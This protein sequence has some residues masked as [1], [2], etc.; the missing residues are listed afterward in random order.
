[1]VS[2]PLFQSRTGYIISSIQFLCLMT[3]GFFFAQNRLALAII[4]LIVAIVCFFLV[5]RIQQSLNQYI[6][7]FFEALKN[8][9]TSFQYPSVIKNKSIRALLE[10]FNILKDRFQHIKVDAEINERYYRAIIRHSA[11]GLLV[12]HND[13]IELINNL[14]CMYA[15]ISSESKN[16]DLLKIKN[17]PFYDAIFE[18]QPGQDITYKHSFGNHIQILLF[19]ATILKRYDESVKLVSI[20]DIRHELESREIDSYKKLIR[21]M[22]HEIM[23]LMSPLTSV[24]KALFETYQP[25]GKPL[26]VGDV[27][28]NMVKNTL[29]SLQVINEQS[30]GILN[31]MENYRRIAQVPNPVIQPFEVRD[32]AEQLRIVFNGPLKEKDISLNIMVDA[33][34]KSINADKNLINQAVINII[35]N[36]V[37]ALDQ[38]DGHKWISIEIS[39]ESGKRCIKISNNGPQISPEL[40]EKIFVP[41]FTTKSN[42][43]GIGLSI[44]QEIIKL[45]KGSLMVFSTKENTSFVIEL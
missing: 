26:E 30:K 34:S 21:V 7:L 28:E 23:N 39:I 2:E 3:S 14:A 19:R 8:N 42:G 29:N 4:L 9:D 1:M 17:R 10:Q 15:G 31:F 22:T 6:T 44:A 37:N 24:S 33:T 45:H 43:S 20:Q 11:T 27:D 40:Q 12:L 36:A 5:R 32:W 25:S 13:K 18:L 41:F 35:N 16:G 38:I